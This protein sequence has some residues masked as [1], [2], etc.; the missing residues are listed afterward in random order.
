MVNRT[1]RRQNLARI[2]EISQIAARH[3][4]GW[5]FG[6]SVPGEQPDD[7]RT[8]GRRLRNLLDDLGPTFVKFGQLVS[9]RPDMVPADIIR[10]LRGLQDQAAPVPVDAVAEV[11]EQELGSPVDELFADFTRAPL[12]SASIGQ[13]H[14]ATLHD[15]TAVV[16]K[17]QR[18]G[19]QRT[20]A[21]DVALMRQLAEV[22][23]ERVR[24][25]QFVDMAGLVDEF[26]ESITRELDY[27]IEARNTEV[28]ARDF[29]E[30]AGV[31]VPAVHWDLTTP[32][33]L[34]MERLPG[35]PLSQLDTDQW[36]VEDR[37]KLAGHISETW[38]QMVFAHGRFHADPH[39]ANI[40]VE[41][42][43]DIGLI[44]FGL[45]GQLTARD[46]EAAVRL[47]MDVLDMNS[48]AIPGRLRA[49]G[50]R[51]PRAIEGQLADQIDVV[52]R[53]HAGQSMGDLDGRALVSEI[54]ATIYRL[55][56][57]LP[58]HW[59]LLDK[60]LA[61][62]AGVALQLSPEFDVFA[63][64]RPYAVRVMTG[65]LRPERILGA[66][67]ADLE[68]YATAFRDY[69]FQVSEVLD[70]LTSGT[71]EGRVHLDGL[72]DTT[73]AAQASINRIALAVMSAALFVSSA[74][75]ATLVEDGPH[76][77]GLSL[78]AA[79]PFAAASGLATWVVLGVARSRR[80]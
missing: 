13:V 37:Q 16:V 45:V 58:S 48:E 65:R 27:G 64:A 20:V 25:L 3:G 19:A 4:F 17:V 28:F 78:T 72:D 47:L 63:R 8:R 67:H 10:E 1:P 77:A 11:I 44:D 57:V 62:L 74:M 5:A 34:V 31:R 69:P 21:A 51:Y 61:T 22:V 71:L 6:R 53:R 55:K 36:S 52:L 75:M 56:V 79:P 70:G 54:F 60:T 15:G 2:G 73:H 35:T 38:M 23:G 76:L 49:L 59:M 66:A 68:R 41:S 12:A 29:A 30:I 50:V 80:W 9:T 14:E 18:P 33:V 24:R 46:R 39:P 7:V 32:R 43:E 40:L 42:P 26:D